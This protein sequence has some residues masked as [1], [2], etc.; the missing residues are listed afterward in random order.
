[1]NKNVSFFRHAYKYY[2]FFQIPSISPP[3]KKK[4]I[5]VSDMSAIE[6]SFF[7]DSL[8]LVTSANFKPSIKS[9]NFSCSMYLLVESIFHIQSAVTESW[10]QSQEVSQVHTCCCCYDCC[11][12]RWGEGG[13]GRDLARLEF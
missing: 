1:M 9:L 13:G 10:L 3:P 6:C 5:F 8:S 11:W 4:Y 12:E 2:F 7:Y